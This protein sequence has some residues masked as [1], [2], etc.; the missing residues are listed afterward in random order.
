[1]DSLLTAGLGF[2]HRAERMDA[3]THGE[4]A[5]TPLDRLSDRA[6][7]CSDGIVGMGFISACDAQGAVRVDRDQV[8]YADAKLA[9]DR[10]IDPAIRRELNRWKRAIR[11]W[12][13]KSTSGRGA[14]AS[15]AG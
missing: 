3:W 15:M 2:N 8:D 11:A 10:L 12:R 7:S 5:S 6:V 4:A 14:T 9:V 13:A 1:M